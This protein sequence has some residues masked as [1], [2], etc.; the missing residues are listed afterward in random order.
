MRVAIILMALAALAVL[1]LLF[2]A[3]TDM[4]SIGIYRPILVAIYIT[5]IPFF[6]ALYHAMKLL[7]YIDTQK[8]F[9]TLS[10]KALGFI[11]YCGLSIGSIYTLGLPYIYIVAQEDDAP[12]VV[13]LG[14]IIAGASLIIATSMGVLQKLLQNAID[15]KSENDLTV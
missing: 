15:M 7:Q 9:S 5:S 2:P 10:V 6:I 13:L 14:L 11:K 3:V 8:A 4:T 12:G 1:I